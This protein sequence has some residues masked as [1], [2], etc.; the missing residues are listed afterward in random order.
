M[1]S[2]EQWVWV[3][4][5]EGEEPWWVWSINSS[6]DYLVVTKADAADAESLRAVLSCA[7]QTS[8]WQ[9]WLEAARRQRADSAN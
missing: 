5:G 8:P 2:Y 4:G 1:A 6:G 7:L 3:T 9:G